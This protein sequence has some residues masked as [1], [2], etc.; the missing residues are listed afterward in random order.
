MVDYVKAGRRVLI[1]IVR[2]EVT[3]MYIWDA[4]D[5]PMITDSEENE[6][7]S[8]WR[9]K[10]LEGGI[11]V[12]EVIL[13]YHAV[14]GIQVTEDTKRMAIVSFVLGRRVMRFQKEHGMA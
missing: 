11:H 2:L 14:L 9:T 13:K 12:A 6:L 5:V 4:L 10:V 1:T 3:E 8:I 7:D